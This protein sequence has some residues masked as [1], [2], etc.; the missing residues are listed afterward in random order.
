MSFVIKDMIERDHPYLVENEFDFTPYNY[1]FIKRTSFTDDTLE[2]DDLK[3]VLDRFEAESRS[4][5]GII[6]YTRPIEQEPE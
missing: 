1:L 6:N 5:L 4:M 2:F 3:E